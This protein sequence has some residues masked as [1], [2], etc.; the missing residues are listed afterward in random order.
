MEEWRKVKTDLICPSCISS[1]VS[2]VMRMQQIRP[3]KGKALTFEKSLHS[4]IL[5]REKT[6]LSHSIWRSSEVPDRQHE[7]R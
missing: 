4:L 2:A 7:A 3:N 1:R 6:K 5:I